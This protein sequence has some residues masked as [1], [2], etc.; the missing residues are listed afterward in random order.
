M[1]NL[2]ILYINHEF[3]LN[4]E[5]LKQY[6][7]NLSEETDAYNDLL[8]NSKAGSLSAWL[9]ERGE[10]ILASKVDK[11][12]KSIGDSEY[13]NI[14]SDIFG[15]ESS[16]SK[17]LFSTC[18]SVGKVNYDVSEENI[19]FFVPISI[20]RAVNEN[21]EL[22]IIT[23]WDKSLVN[24]NTSNYMDGEK[25]TLELKL[26]P[27][28]DNSIKE[29]C[30]LIDNSES[31]RFTVFSFY[32]G[33]TQFLIETR[34]SRKNDYVDIFDSNGQ[35]V[36]KN[37]I[38]IYFCPNPAYVLGYCTDDKTVYFVSEKGINP[39]C[40]WD[41]NFND[42][43]YSRKLGCILGY[44]D[45]IELSNSDGIANN[46]VVQNGLC[47]PEEDYIQNFCKVNNI[48]KE[49]LNSKTING[50]K[51][52]YIGKK[53]TLPIYLEEENNN[54]LDANGGFVSLYSYNGSAVPTFDESMYIA[55][56]H[57]PK[58]DMCILMS[59]DGRAVKT[60]NLK[61]NIGVSILNETSTSI[62]LGATVKYL[63]SNGNGTMINYVR[64][65][66]Y[67]YIKKGVFWEKNY[68]AADCTP[69]LYLSLDDV[70]VLSI[71]YSSM[72]SNGYFEDLGSGFI[73]VMKNDS[74]NSII[75]LSPEGKIIY[76][77]KKTES[78]NRNGFGK[79]EGAFIVKDTQK[80]IYSVVAYDGNKICSF[81]TTNKIYSGYHSGNIVFHNLNTIGY[82]DETGV[83]HNIPW[84]NNLYIQSIK[85]LKNGNIL[86][87]RDTSSTKWILI[88]T[89][90]S[91]L[92]S[93]S[94]SID[95]I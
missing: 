88:N 11:V 46:F 37:L 55:T 49:Y 39:I 57:G 35:A 67:F 27:M 56:N 4:I 47:I 34:K 75:V 90:G 25:V 89:E 14:L 85:V 17:P 36:K 64:V 62:T 78:I 18:F 50:R 20:I 45:I 70:K 21:F 8:Y 23:D 73:A 74:R 65:N 66:D 81:T 12:D 16:L 68:S 38:K 3:C 40:A 94:H 61:Q 30:I 77:L 69:E 84:K 51:V 87:R 13:M 42:E 71:Q 33:N 44:I 76:T 22:A 93:S 80:P 15:S 54:I 28:P 48:P 10:N 31:Y 72:F 9:C 1:D 19:I 82:F 6:F 91:T 58:Y 26:S 2:H 43:I 32:G 60:Y 63:K 53:D 86:V 83:S 7:Q 59:T 5:K 41:G 52:R 24:I 29:A 92:L 79:S 95:V